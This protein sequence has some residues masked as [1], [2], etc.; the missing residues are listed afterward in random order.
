MELEKIVS[1]KLSLDV[2]KLNFEIFFV[3]IVL[4]NTL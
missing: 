1:I 3:L 4:M 2:V